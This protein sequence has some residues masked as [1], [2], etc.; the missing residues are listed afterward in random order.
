MISAGMLLICTVLLLVTNHLSL[1]DG[2][3]E[4]TSAIATVGL[5]RDVTPTLNVCGKLLIILCMYLGRV[6]PI[7][8]FMFFGQR[9]ANRNNVRYADAEIIVG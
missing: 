8:M 6:G 4:V 7:T 2:L 5:S 9:A 3:Y 1:S